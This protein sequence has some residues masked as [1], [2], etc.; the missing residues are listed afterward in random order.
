MQIYY[1]EHFLHGY[2]FLGNIF[3]SIWLSVPDDIDRNYLSHPTG[4]RQVGHH[5]AGA[6]RP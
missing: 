2:E 1:T 5:E 3:V 6:D 4:S